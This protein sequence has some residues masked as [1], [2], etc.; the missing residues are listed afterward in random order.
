METKQKMTR[1]IQMEK[2]TEK[3]TNG[4]IDREKKETNGN[5]NKDDGKQPN[6]EMDPE[7]QE[8]NQDTN[9]NEKEDDQ[10]KANEKLSKK[11]KNRKNKQMETKLYIQLKSW[12]LTIHNRKKF[13]LIT[14]NLE[15]V[16]L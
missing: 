7:K 9:G 14:V 13:S 3:N 4:K 15:Q 6:G 11:K 10:K 16:N 5:K 1:K 12:L 2:L 8:K